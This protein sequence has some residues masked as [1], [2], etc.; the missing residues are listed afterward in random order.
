M[1]DDKPNPDD[2]T[3]DRTAADSGRPAAAL[4]PR[5]IGRA[6]EPRLLYPAIAILSLVAIW[7]T[8][9]HLIKVERTAAERAA[10]A[11]SRQLAETY[12]AQVVR[13][14]R[15]IDQTLKFVKYA[16]EL[17]DKPSLLSELRERALLPPPLLFEISIANSSGDI[18]ASTHP[19]AIAN[20]AD[21]DVFQSQRGEDIFAVGRPRLGPG[22]D[23][24]RLEFSHRL[25]APDGAFA[26]IVMLS[27]DAS[28]F[29]SGYES[30]QLGDHGV[31][32]L[33]GTDGMFRVRRSG[34]VVSAGDQTDFATDAI[35]SPDEPVGEPVITTDPWDGAR[36]YT[37]ARELYAVP[38]IVTVGLSVDERL[39]GTRHAAKTY[40]WRAVAAS[41]LLVG[42]ITVF[43]RMSMQLT[44]SR[45]R[46]VEQRL[47]HAARDEYL[48]YHDSLTTLP[49]RSLFS[50]LL[51]QGIQQANRYNRRLSV[52]FLDLDRFKFINDTLGHEAGDQLLQEVANRL[53]TCL[54]G[55]D[56]VARLGG[57]EFVILLPEMQEDKYA[58]TVAQKILSVAGRPFLLRGKEVRVTA[59]IGISVYPQDGLDEQTLIK[60]ADTAMYQ[61]KQ[62]GKNNYQFYSEKLNTESLARLTLESGLRHALERDE[63]E[64][65]YQIKQDLLSGRTT[66]MEALLRWRHPDLGILPP[67]QFIPVAEG[68][69]LIVPI[70]KWVLRTACAQNAAWQREGLPRLTMSVNMSVRQLY[71]EH[72]PEDLRAI[73]ADTG[74]DP[75]LLE[76]EISE[77]LLMR[78]AEKNLLT[79]TRIKEMGIRIA[80]DDFGVGYSSL[81]TLKRLPL[82]TIKIDRA[83][84]RDLV[85]V[86]ANREL[87]KATIAVGKAL[88]MTIVAQGVETKEQAEYLRRN[89]CTELQGFLIS[90]P[91]PADKIAELLRTQA[92]RNDADTPAVD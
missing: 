31:I 67:M 63:F 15:E 10:L 36:R 70:G 8:T 80:I 40:R 16:Y 38:L 18:L 45:Q 60:N 72:L 14:L 32:G 6:M 74:M 73:L 58:A 71:D 68:T 22:S 92:T 49:N 35:R 87:T 55:S 37:S 77:S 81:A 88:S 47:A 44:R 41:L 13:A 12:E 53:K 59:S 56:V 34:N 19:P 62:E 91:V 24:W 75:N 52:L 5:W 2:P 25:N 54:R 86:D 79:L 89:A 66:G 61:A 48:A 23:A 30:S 1:D 9:L 17:K 27:V 42:V 26:G 82:D 11:S 46:V 51:S 69:G 29:V 20:V 85:N 43:G 21:W 64:L 65:H 39:A 90:E 50:R 76:L 33:L 78:D 84:I 7:G 57:D 28:Y 3:A 83:Y 4:I